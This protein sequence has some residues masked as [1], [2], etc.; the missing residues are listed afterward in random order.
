M[1]I[2][3]LGL[4]LLL[5]ACSNASSSN[6][7]TKADLDAAIQELR[8]DLPSV[9][10]AETA[11]LH[12]D[13]ARVERQ[14]GPRSGALE[15]STARIHLF[16]VIRYDG[17]DCTG[18]GYVQIG[19][20]GAKQGFVFAE[21]TLP[22]EERR[23][24]MVAPGTPQS[25]FVLASRLISGTGCESAEGQTNGYLVVENDVEVCSVPDG[26]I[27]TEMWPAGAPPQS[28]IHTAAVQEAWTRKGRLVVVPSEVMPTVVV[29][30]GNGD[31]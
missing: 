9:V 19:R 14:Q 24:L 28:T 7:V 13:L 3:V 10:A 20:A 1:R 12:N 4:T 23:Y 26:G 31:D 15:K 25:E 27:P 8:A 16:G 5:A 30:T 22:F 18:N 6:N 2:I 11:N 29:G 17:P 21:P